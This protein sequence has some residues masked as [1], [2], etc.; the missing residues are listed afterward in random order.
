MGERP[1]L[2]VRVGVE[3]CLQCRRGKTSYAKLV[4]RKHDWDGGRDSQGGFSQRARVQSRVGGWGQ[5]K[6]AAFGQEHGG[7]AEQE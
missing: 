5:G 3:T 1:P 4:R 6:E 2:D 7:L